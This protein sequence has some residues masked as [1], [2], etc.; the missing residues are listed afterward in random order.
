MFIGNRYFASAISYVT[1]AA[2]IIQS[3]PNSSVVNLIVRIDKLSRELDV[4]NPGIRKSH[5][6]SAN[7]RN[8]AVIRIG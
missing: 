5:S 2:G 6:A 3:K 1:S 7:N 4:I 8:A